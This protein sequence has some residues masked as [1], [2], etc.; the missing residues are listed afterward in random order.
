MNAIRLMV[1]CYPSNGFLWEAIFCETLHIALIF[2]LH[3][4][5]CTKYTSSIRCLLNRAFKYM[6]FTTLLLTYNLRKINLQSASLC[7]PGGDSY[8]GVTSCE[9]YQLMEEMFYV[10]Y[11]VFSSN[12][13]NSRRFYLAW[14]G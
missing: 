12:V 8:K 13:H 6:F 1:Q 10:L 3:L 11:T 2:W 14:V 5:A 7:P 9:N 4:L